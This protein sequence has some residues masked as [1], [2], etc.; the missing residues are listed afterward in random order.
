LKKE[1]RNK[2]SALNKAIH[3]GE[4]NISGAG[5]NMGA[6]SAAISADRDWNTALDLVDAAEKG[7]LLNQYVFQTIIRPRI[8]KWTPSYYISKAVKGNILEKE[9]FKNKL[10]VQVGVTSISVRGGDHFGMSAKALKTMTKVDKT[11][12]EAK[13][14]IP[15]LEGKF[16][17]SHG[18]TND[19]VDALKAGKAWLKKNKLKFRLAY[20]TS[21]ELLDN[22]QNREILGKI[23]GKALIHRQNP[24]AFSD[25]SKEKT[26]L[27]NKY[28]GFLSRVQ[29]S[30]Y[31]KAYRA[32]FKTGDVFR[33]KV[34]QK[35]MM[36]VERAIENLI[37]A[38]TGGIG[39]L[40]AMAIRVVAAKVLSKAIA[41]MADMFKNLRG[42]N[43]DD[44]YDL[45]LEAIKVAVGCLLGCI[46]CCSFLVFSIVMLVMGFIS[47]LKGEDFTPLGGNIIGGGSHVEIE[48]MS[49]FDV[50]DSD[51]LDPSR[52]TDVDQ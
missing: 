48:T 18:L 1:V 29:A 10:K 28:T 27:L 16:M 14:L 49:E 41:I 6:I 8:E 2:K 50:S 26:S 42:F 12:G 44:M 19:D 38:A 31:G 35:L 5:K 24:S 45:M 46:A 20:G 22:A 51:D 15:L 32:I 39:K 33:Q 17:A 3:S 52:I 9:R 23:Y 11:T 47:A 25:P 36:L 40:V 4:A 43:F 30:T 7:N 34:T 21:G 37:G 13:S